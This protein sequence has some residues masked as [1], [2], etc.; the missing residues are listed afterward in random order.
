[1]QKC[2][3]Y[4]KYKKIALYG[5]G[6]NAKKFIDEKNDI[7]I[8]CILD[9]KK[10]EGV[11]EGYPILSLEDA[12]D[13]N[14]DLVII[15]SA[16]NNEKIIYD[17]IS[18][19]CKANSIT[20]MD[21][22]GNNL[23]ETLDSKVWECNSSEKID[24]DFLKSEI[25]SHD[26]ITFDIFDTLLMRRTLTPEDV[27]DIVE[28]RIKDEGIIIPEF[29]VK[30]MIAERLAIE[31]N[32]HTL[33][34][35]YIALKRQENLSDRECEIIKEIEIAVERDVIISRSRMVD[36]YRKA[37]ALNKKI[38]LVS[39]MYLPESILGELLHNNGIKGYDGILIS[40]FEGVPKTNGLFGV[41]KSKVHGK[42]FLHIGDNKVAD[43]LAAQIYGIDSFIIP[44]SR[45]MLYKM[46]SYMAFAAAGINERSLLGAYISILFND[47]FTRCIGK[48][49]ESMTLY[50]YCRCFIAP[51]V[52]VF[53]VWIVVQA[54]KSKYKQILFASRDGYIF[55]KLY[56]KYNLAKYFG[57]LPDAVYFYTSRKAAVNSSINDVTDIYDIRKK[58]GTNVLN[59]IYLEEVSNTEHAICLSQKYRENYKIY[60]SKNN[61]D[62]S[63][64]VFVDL[65]SSGTSQYYLNRGLNKDLNGY[66]M[67]INIGTS[68][69]NINVK[70]MMNKL[71]TDAYSF[72]VSE[73]FILENVLTSP[74]ASV[75]CFDGN[76]EPVFDS[77][78]KDNHQLKWLQE[79]FNGIES[80][81]LTFIDK[82]YIPH[83][84]LN[85]T[86]GEM[87]FFSH[88]YIDEETEN[89]LFSVVSFIDN[90]INKPMGKNG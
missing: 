87:L 56:K 30:R 54:A 7:S 24:A 50:D 12:V 17:R 74:E 29:K 76:G 35:I 10:S 21:R 67:G 81:Y 65:I 60:L 42:R 26:V 9:G 49:I 3:T 1:M 25:E 27:F 22:F 33:D 43:G 45:S 41:L 78:H 58:I 73:V 2:T 90:L 11:F 72:N 64:G 71:D 37:K 36:T 39:D 83:A 85:S 68:L 44:S 69:G 28:Y 5:T 89:K 66:Y 16:L 47:P 18:D 48:K 52:T 80:F 32:N 8:Y 86:I 61:I 53:M 75:I 14:I 59:E 57:E 15:L 31:K 77:N 55:Y 84:P 70:Y 13:N 79:C 88:H 62:L 46:N 51:L 23:T 38:Y 19:I 63:R 4:Q 82:L 6:L 40:G 20:V 34:G